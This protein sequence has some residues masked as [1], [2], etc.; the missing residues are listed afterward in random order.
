MNEKTLKNYSDGDSY[1]F[2]LKE[3]DTLENKNNKY[4]NFI[5]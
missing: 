2:L 4:N 5:K 3:I 1:L